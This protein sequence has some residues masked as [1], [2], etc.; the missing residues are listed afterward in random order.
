MEVGFGWLLGGRAM[1]HRGEW[2]CRLKPGALTCGIN[3]DYDP[4]PLYCVSNR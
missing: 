2:G 3:E 4:M 1:I